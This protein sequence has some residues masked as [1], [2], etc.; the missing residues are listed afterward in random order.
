MEC[1]ILFTRNNK[2]IIVSLSSDELVQRLLKVIGKGPTVSIKILSFT[3]LGAVL[4]KVNHKIRKI[5]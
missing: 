5:L 4:I 2:K 1:Q 3:Y